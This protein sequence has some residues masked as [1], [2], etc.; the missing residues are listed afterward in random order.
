MTACCCHW[1]LNLSLPEGLYK[2]VSC[3]RSLILLLFHFT[4]VLVTSINCQRQGQAFLKH[5]PNCHYTTLKPS[6]FSI[7]FFNV[8]CERFVR[9]L[10]ALLGLISPD[11]PHLGPPPTP[12]P[13]WPRSIFKLSPGLLACLVCAVELLVSFCLTTGA[14]DPVEQCPGLNLNLPHRQD[15]AR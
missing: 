10:T 3:A 4:R 9:V 15:L 12:S 13:H 14:F 2:W 7:I 5:P 1:L 6:V 11:Q 8:H